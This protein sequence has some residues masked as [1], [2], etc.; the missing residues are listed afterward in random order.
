MSTEN[1]CVDT[2]RH[3]RRPHTWN[4]E[5]PPPA[6][7]AACSCSRAAASLSACASLRAESHKNNVDEEPAPRED[8]GK[9]IGDLEIHYIFVCEGSYASVQEHGPSKDPHFAFVDR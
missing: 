2:L 3:L 8:E 6:A 9:A 1:T 5:R 7:L 4:D